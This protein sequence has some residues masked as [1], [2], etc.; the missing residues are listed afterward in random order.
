MEETQATHDSVCAAGKMFPRRDV[1]KSEDIFE[2]SIELSYEEVVAPPG[3]TAVSL[4]EEYDKMMTQRDKTSE[5]KGNISVPDAAKKETKLS[6]HKFVLKT[7]E[8]TIVGEDN[9]SKGSTLPDKPL[10]ERTEELLVTPDRKIDFS[11][12]DILIEKQRQIALKKKGVRE[13]DTKKTEYSD[14]DES[15]EVKIRTDKAKAQMI[16][17][18]DT[19][20]DERRVLTEKSVK[21]GDQVTS[22]TSI[23]K[24]RRL[25]PVT[26]M[27]KEAEVPA[28]DRPVEAVASQMRTVTDMRRVV[29]TQIQPTVITDSSRETVLEDLSL[30]KPEAAQEHKSDVSFKKKG[31]SRVE[32]S[33]EETWIQKEPDIE[34]KRPKVI[35]QDSAVFSTTTEGLPRKEE[36][37]GYR[38]LIKESVVE[39]LAGAK[40]VVPLK[41]AEKKKSSSQTTSRGINRPSKLFIVKPLQSNPSKR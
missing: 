13:Q 20:S 31:V 27:I 29:E 36:K 23:E 15:V 8:V 1:G 41:S 17:S 16:I 35:Q 34:S 5:L 4:S 24:D 40:P 25:E 22:A 26:E 30:I 33:R 14:K 9:I 10:R 37:S 12:E 38:P 18:T 2:Q 21:R 28:K 7:Q 39:K 32:G 6:K 11:H 19:S 3:K